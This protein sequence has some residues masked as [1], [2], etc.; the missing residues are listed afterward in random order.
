[1]MLEYLGEREA[2]A[3]ILASIEKVLGE[4]IE[5]LKQ[6]GVDVL[7]PDMGG[8]GTTESLGNAIEEAIRLL[9]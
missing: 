7:T 8:K 5:R 1:M 3:H 6:G 2:A 9:P 4:S